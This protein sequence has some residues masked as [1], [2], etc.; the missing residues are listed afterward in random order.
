MMPKMLSWPILSLFC[1]NLV[2]TY[3]DIIEWLQHSFFNYEGKKGA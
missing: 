1:S 2:Y 3:L